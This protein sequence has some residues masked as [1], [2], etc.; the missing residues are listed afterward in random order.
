MS[1]QRIAV[2]QAPSLPGQL[3]HNVG[4]AVGLISAAADAGAGIVVLPELFLSGYDPAGIARDPAAHV[5]S[6]ED[7]QC[8]RIADKAAARGIAA[9]V[10]AAVETGAGVANAAIVFAPDGRVVHVYAKAKLWGEEAEVFAP[11]AGPVVVDLA[12]TRVGMSICFDAGFPEHMR[13]LALAGADIIA[14]P[15]AFAVGAERRRYE[16]Y[17]PCRA[18]ENTVMIAVSNAIG[19]QGGLEMFGDSVLFGP[20]GDEL[21]RVREPTGLAAAA[22]DMDAIASARGDLPYLALVDKDPV[23]VPVIN[24]R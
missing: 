18:L 3:D 4:Q 9:I 1:A 23:E 17:F 10:G 5:V 20:R 15:A 6:A 14:C 21:A 24:W 19:A 22:I 7:A 11:G 13:A 16:T 8:R 2:A 12:G